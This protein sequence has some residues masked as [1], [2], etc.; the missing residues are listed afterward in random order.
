MES[1]PIRILSIKT[2]TK[3]SEDGKTALLTFTS[4]AAPIQLRCH[5]DILHSVIVELQRVVASMHIR[6]D[7]LSLD[8]ETAE[9][10]EPLSVEKIFNRPYFRISAPKK[11][12]R[13][14]TL[15]ISSG[16]MADLV[17][18]LASLQA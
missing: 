11:S 2:D 10:A 18:D 17:S 6:T 8:G 13:M 3:L 1:E 16:Q 7:A 14:A 4:H 12:G 5:T 9:P 15:V